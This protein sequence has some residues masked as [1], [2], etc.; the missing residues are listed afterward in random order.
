MQAIVLNEYGS[1]E[2]L[3]LQSVPDPQPGTGE[4]LVQVAATALNRADCLQRQ[5]LYPP[6]GGAPE[7]EIPG[8]EFAGEIAALGHGVQGVAVG[9]RVCG[10]LSAGGYA[11]RVVTPASMLI[12]IPET[13]SYEQAAAIPE[14]FMTAWDALFARGQL[15]LGDSVLIHAGGSGVGTA[16]IQL[17]HRAGA[18]VLATFGSTEKLESARP[19]GLDV[20]ILYREQAL[21]QVVQE[22]TDAGADVIIDFIGAAALEQNLKAAALCGRI[23]V[24]GLMGGVSGEISLGLLLAK[25]LSLI[26]TVLRARSLDEKVL[27]SRTVTRQLMPLFASG[28]LQPVIDSVLPLAQAPE[29]HRR[30]EANLNFGKIILTI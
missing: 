15:G 27:L 7:H 2:V 21:E 13:L 8:L 12:P 28:A 11:E 14:V 9:D 4:V 25:R 23:V 19:L 26:G 20:G 17:A 16:A 22:Q 29:G 10:L 24:V 30:M 18:K 3:Q 6:P 5:G 1:P